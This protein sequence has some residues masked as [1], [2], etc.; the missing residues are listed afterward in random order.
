MVEIQ[1]LM[2]G[3]DLSS[4][5]NVLAGVIA[6][7]IAY[8]K[9][10]PLLPRSSNKI[11]SDIELYNKIIESD[12]G[13]AKFI[14]DAIERDIKKKYSKTLSIHNIPLFITAVLPL[15]G[16]CYMIYERIVNE[17]IT[18]TFF[19]LLFIAF[20]LFAFA[21]GSFTET[22]TAE[23]N[24]KE[25]KIRN[26]AFRITLYSWGELIMGLFFSSIFSY[27]T[28]YLLFKTGAYNFDGW[29]LLT[30]V[31]TIGGFALTAK[32]FKSQAD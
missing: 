20:M 25:N 27:W 1:K 31:C 24:D 30:F 15:V 22:K 14:K 26:P 23:Q 11:L 5:L 8:L 7:F 32:S 29:S 18:P 13:N 2:T 9:I 16:V 17:N 12:L 6:F 4:L 3:I 28:Y 10:V 21:V 19:V